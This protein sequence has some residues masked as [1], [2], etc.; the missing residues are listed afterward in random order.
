[1]RA[2]GIVKLLP[3]AEGSAAT[4]YH[5]AMLLAQPFH[6]SNAAARVEQVGG[7]IVGREETLRLPCRFE[8]TLDLL[9]L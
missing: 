2:A 8:P 6:R 5:A 9:A 3:G 7:F 1:M 4:A